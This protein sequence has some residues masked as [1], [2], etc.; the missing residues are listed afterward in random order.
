MV[1]PS[2][3]IARLRSA[4]TPVRRVAIA[5]RARGTRRLLSPVRKSKR[6]SRHRGI[7]SSLVSRRVC[8]RASQRGHSRRLPA[9]NPT[10]LNDGTVVPHFLLAQV[11]PALAA[12]VRNV[13]SKMKTAEC[14]HSG[15]ATLLRS[16]PRAGNRQYRSTA[17]CKNIRLEQ[18]ADAS[19]RRSPHD[20]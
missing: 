17:A 19:Q 20:A 6:G 10:P 11:R 2:A 1:L 13:I 4:Q 16:N 3:V 9:E 14:F 15:F 5:D 18:T 7:L 12:T 8:V